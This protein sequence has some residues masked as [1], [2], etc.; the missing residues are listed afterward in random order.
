MPSFHKT[1]DVSTF[2]IFYRF[3]AV[4]SFTADSSLLQPTEG[5]NTTPHTVHF[6]QL[7][8]FMRVHAWL[9]FGSALTHPCMV[10]CALLLCVSLIASTSPFTFSSSSSSL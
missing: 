2:K 7:F 3:V 10:I 1:S 4:K 6:P 5:V 8:T 9:K